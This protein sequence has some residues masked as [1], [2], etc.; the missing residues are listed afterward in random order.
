MTEH[1]RRTLRQAIIDELLRVPERLAP[2]VAAETDPARIELLLG[3]AFL[4]AIDGTTI[5]FLE[6]LESP[7]EEER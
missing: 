7:S 5:D 1:Q 2:A 6:R 3:E 4:A